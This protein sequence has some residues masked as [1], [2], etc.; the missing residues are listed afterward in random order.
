[1]KL[2]ARCQLGLY[3]CESLIGNRRPISKMDHSP[4]PWQK[5]GIPYHMGL[6][7]WN[8]FMF[9][10]NS[11]WHSPDWVTQRTSME[12]TSPLKIY[13]QSFTSSLHYILL[14]VIHQVPPTLKGRLIRLHFLKEG[15]S[16]N[17]WASFRTSTERSLFLFRANS[18]T[19]ELD[20]ILSH[21]HFTN[22][23]CSF[24]RC[25]LGFFVC[26]FDFGC[27]GS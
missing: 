6:L 24:L 2:Q 18:S 14:E 22:W 19:H 10:W 3:S 7:H 4:G 16:K 23:L 11:R 1:M 12:V 25:F 15:E 5:S 27:A 20:S 26:L 17:L 21:L 9:S 8:A 13:C